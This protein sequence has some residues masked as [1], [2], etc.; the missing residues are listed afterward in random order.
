MKNKIILSALIFFF[1]FLNLVSSIEA[2][3]VAMIVKDSSSLS[4]LYEKKIK[5]ILTD[6]GLD[7]TLVDKNTVVEYNNFDLIVVAGRPLTASSS[8]MLDSFVKDIPV[9]DVPTLAIDSQFVGDWGWVDVSGLSSLSSSQPQKVLIKAVHPLTQGYLLDQLVQVHVVS[10]YNTVDLE[11]DYTKLKI[12][13]S[14]DYAGKYGSILYGNPNTQLHSGKKVSN[15]SAIV[16]FGT[17]YPY[18]WTDDAEQLFENAVNWLVNMNFTPPTS[19]VLS[20]PASSR[21]STALYQWTASVPSSDIQYYQFQLSNS[22]DFSTTL[23]DT[24]TTSL[25]YSATLTD[26]QTYYARVKSVNWIDVSSDWSNTIK[27]I[28]DFS[29]LIVTINSPLTDSTFKIG[30]SVSIDATVTADRPI[31]SCSVSI[32]SQTTDLTYANSTCSGSITIPNIPE[33]Q[34]TLAVSATNNLGSTNSSTIL[35]TIQVAP[36]PSPAPSSTPTYTGSGGVSIGS[37]ALTFT[38]PL[39]VTGYAGEKVEFN[40]VVRN[41]WSTTQKSVKIKINDLSIPYTVNPEQTDVPGGSSQTFAVTLNIPKD[42]S[43]KYEFQAVMTTSHS[44]IPKHVTL[45]VLPARKFLPMVSATDVLIPA[46]YSGEPTKVGIKLKNTGN[47][48]ARISET[49]S[50]PEEWKFDVN[51]F[52]VEIEPNMED[53]VTF[54]VTPYKNSGKIDFTTSYLSDGKQIS[55]TK[56]SETAINFRQQQSSLTGLFTAVSDPVVAIPVLAASIFLGYTFFKLMFGKK[57]FLDEELIPKTIP[58]ISRSISSINPAYK[59]WENKF[60]GKL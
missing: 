41:F 28:A 24:K 46:F 54:D 10:G 48:T 56:T 55:F 36:A 25:Q 18:Y 57:S 12:V 20:G 27:T 34:T 9:N 14:V 16:F 31:T 23:V 38:V 7:V 2:K 43:G 15:H 21:T 33:G 4:S 51:S 5:N 49:V 3:N 32:G 58:K 11:K 60:K 59:R 17:A 13:A 47:A 19:P 29:D 30:D 1:L 39:E 45:N 52:Y 6:M 37:T 53:T 26:G 35:I 44:Y 8:D 22:P 42:F 50:Y 40:A